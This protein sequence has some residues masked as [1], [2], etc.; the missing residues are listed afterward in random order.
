MIFFSAL[1][2][3]LAIATLAYLVFAL[4]KPERF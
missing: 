1:A 2:T 3:V 4:V